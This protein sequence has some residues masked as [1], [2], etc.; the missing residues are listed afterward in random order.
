MVDYRNEDSI[1]KNE[2]LSYLVRAILVIGLI[3]GEHK[4]R[5]Y[6]FRNHIIGNHSKN[7]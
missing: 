5:P 2:H 4:I 7:E 3:K 6:T 1:M